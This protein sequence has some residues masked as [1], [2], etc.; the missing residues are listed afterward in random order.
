MSGT[1]VRI[2]ALES[3]T[4]LRPLTNFNRAV[5]FLDLG[6]LVVAN[7]IMKTRY[8]VRNIAHR[9]KQSVLLK[10]ILTDAPYMAFVVG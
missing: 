8:P 10:E 7:L 9:Q 6:L 1:S 3:D 4:H 5:A 2:I